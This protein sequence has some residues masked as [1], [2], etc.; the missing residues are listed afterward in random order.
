MAD[1]RTGELIKVREGAAVWRRIDD[2][3]V[4]LALDSSTYIG[5]NHTGTELWPAMVEGT[6][7]DELVERLVARF[8]VDAQRA[9]ADV[10]AFVDA[11][12]AHS[13]LVDAG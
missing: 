9:A 5:V 12:R 6:T 11:C 1:P 7:R 13:L 2:E 8:D 4:L 3:T 10:D